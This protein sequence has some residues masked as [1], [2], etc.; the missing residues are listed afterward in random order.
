MK[1]LISV[2][3]AAIGTFGFGILY[4]I[5][6]KKLMLATL[7]GVLG[8]AMYH[9]AAIWSVSENVRYLLAAA[10]VTAFSEIFARVEKTP[11]T[12]F[13]APGVIPLVPGSGLYSSMNYAMKEQWDLFAETALTTLELAAFIAI[14]IIAATS[15][16]RI[17]AALRATMKKELQK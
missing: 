2:L 3:A 13:L 8:W 6:G 5:R 17:C 16:F 9:A 14:G 10:A 15:V 11:A 1:I 4:N 12:T 7:A